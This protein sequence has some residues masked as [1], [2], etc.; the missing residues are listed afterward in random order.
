MVIWMEKY[1]IIYEKLKN[2]WSDNIFGPELENHV[3]KLTTTFKKMFISYKVIICSTAVLYI[4]KPWISKVRTLITMWYLPCD[5]A[6]DNCFKTMLTAQTIYYATLTVT[7]LTHD[8][9]FF[10]LLF[11]VYKEFEKI[12]YGLTNVPINEESV[13]DDKEVLDRIAMTVEH[14]NFLLE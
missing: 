5:I 8:A 4:S 3:N 2:T 9:L 7:V 13:G 1:V 6:E 12:K 11:H 10:G 14:H